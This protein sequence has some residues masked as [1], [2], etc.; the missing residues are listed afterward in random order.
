MLFAGTVYIICLKEEHTSFRKSAAKLNVSYTNQRRE[1]NTVLN[2]KIPML[3][4]VN[5]HHKVL[6]NSIQYQTLF[7][8]I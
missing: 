8:D 4:Y 3:P 7:K 1:T 6:V 5:L 2:E